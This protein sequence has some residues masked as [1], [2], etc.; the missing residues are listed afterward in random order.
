MIERGSVGAGRGVGEV[1]PRYRGRR[2][3]HNP[4]RLLAPPL[5]RLLHPPE[6]AQAQEDDLKAGPLL[7]HDCFELRLS[8][9][10]PCNH[11]LATYCNRPASLLRKAKRERRN[12]I[13][14]I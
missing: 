14:F 8:G 1:I 12:V 2:L 6:T 3:L 4:S 13:K 5:D 7:I 9:Y 11:V 10:S